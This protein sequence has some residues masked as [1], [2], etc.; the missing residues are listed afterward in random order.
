MFEHSVTT[1]PLQ[2]KRILVTRT[3]EQASVLCEQ[4]RALGAI[5]IEF[6]TIKIVPPSDWTQLD[7]ALK[8]LYAQQENEQDSSSH[9]RDGYDWLIFTSANGVHVCC[10]RLRQLGYDFQALAN[11]HIATIG[12]AT[13]AALTHYG[14]KADLV[15]DEYI[16]EGVA[17]ALIASTS[18]DGGGG[19]AERGPLWSS[20]QSTSRD[21]GGGEAERGPLWSSALENKGDH[22]DVQGEATDDH[23]G[24]HPSHSTAPV[25][26]G[27]L[28]GQRILLARAAEARKVLVTQLEQ[29]EAVVDEVAAYYTVAVAR[30]D[31]QGREIVRLLE[32]RQLD[33]LTFTSSSTVR[34][35]MAW[36]RSYE[37][38]TSTSLM[39]LVS[40][41]FIACIGPITAQTARELG[42][43]VTIEAKEFTIDGLVQAI[44][45]YEGK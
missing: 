31:E 45:A 25:P 17:A 43:N 28:Q 35:F 6:P 40:K 16:A 8:R 36:L 34:N 32:A 13:A 23:K 10:G 21:G 14:L 9:E 33:I 30:D 1:S 4:L 37:Q 2:G 5:P 7:A 38:A 24:P 27:R 12:P 22:S 29:A 26:T 42:L 3:R 11:V 18:R 19:E 15:P 44:I 41:C 39:E 20:A